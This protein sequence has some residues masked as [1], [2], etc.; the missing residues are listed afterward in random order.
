MSKIVAAAAIRGAR[1]LA[2]EAEQF[3]NKAIQEKGKDS[4]VGFPET[5]FY[6][7]MAYALLGAEVKTLAEMVPVL[8]HL[9]SLRPACGR[10]DCGAALSLRAGTAGRLRRVLFGYDF[11]KPG[12]SAG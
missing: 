1:K 6:L 9:K 5:A 7:P 4:K 12:N 11:K 8:E 3:L 2:Q 10:T